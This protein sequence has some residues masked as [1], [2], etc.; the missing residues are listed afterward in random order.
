M[1]ADV[2]PTAIVDAR[3]TL[4][5]GVKVGPYCQVGPGVVI[6]AG[7]ELS[8]HAVVLGPTRMGRGNR[9]HPFAV[10]GG[11]PQ[12]R[13]YMGEE[14]QLEIGDHNVF[15]EHVTVQRG[16]HK[17]GGVTRIGSRCLLM[18]GAHV[19][20]DVCI[21]DDVTLTNLTTLG[22]HV[23]VGPGAVCGGQVAVAQ[24]VR[25][26]RSCFVAGGARV[27]RDIPPFTIAAGDRARVR[28]L[29]RVGLERAGA[30]VP[31][32]QALKRAFRV[33]F[34]SQVPRRAAI[35]HVR[36]ELG[37]DAWVHELLEFLASSEACQRPS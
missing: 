31:S 17:G 25:L 2:H 30:P 29:N 32:R 15:R 6:G 23:V 33:L 9:V 27:E 1:T 24:F 8:A 20:H 7:S 10:I 26:G 3:A 14:T 11:T 19:A 5:D 12:D 18:V 36:S 4:A 37:H 28:A 21:A 13:S 22:G 34:R 16:T 35:E